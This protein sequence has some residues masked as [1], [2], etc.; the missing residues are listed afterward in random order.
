MEK[1]NEKPVM[2]I[3]YNQSNHPPPPV[4]APP[5]Q[6]YYVRN[7]PY[8]ADQIPLSAAFGDPKGVP[9][10]QTIYR[11]TLAPVNC[12]FCGGFDL[13]TGDREQQ[14]VTTT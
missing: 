9:L 11:D 1:K 5:Q 4:Y 6:Q 10:H 8:Q 13:T 3:P 14:K 12:A 7:N 2:G